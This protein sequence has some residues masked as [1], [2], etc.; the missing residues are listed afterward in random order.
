MESKDILT[1][2][3]ENPSRREILAHWDPENEVFWKR[4]GERIAKQN[5]YTSTW[6][7]TLSFV[8]WTM[9]ATIAAQL[10][11]VG[12]HFTDNEIFTLAALPGLVGATG[13]L[14]YTYLPACRRRRSQLDVHLDGAAARPAHRSRQCPDRHDDKL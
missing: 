2:L 10:N 5:L 14:I 4:W 12:F 8:A 13:R 7:L 1:V 6:A 9:W 3:G 11:Q